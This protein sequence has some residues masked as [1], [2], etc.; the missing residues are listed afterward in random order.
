MNRAE[1][2]E[3]RGEGRKEGRESLERNVKTRKAG[4]LGR[5]G[6]HLIQIELR[7]YTKEYRE[8]KLER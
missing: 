6:E 5:S 3:L 1:Q 7:K 8:I 2:A 4:S